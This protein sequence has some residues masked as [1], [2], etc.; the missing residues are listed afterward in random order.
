MTTGK[1]NST[2]SNTPTA[3]SAEAVDKS[4]RARQL[5]ATVRQGRR[6]HIDV[7]DEGWIEGYLCGW[8][9]D[10]YFVLVPDGERVEKYLIPKSHILMIQLVD[11][12]TFREEA[13]FEQME[14]IVKPFRDVINNQY[15]K[16]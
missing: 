1:I 5:V 7:L 2:L 8:D 11:D 9:S 4:M 15:P 6:I 16:Q 14:P 12:R 3:V 13:L 10:T